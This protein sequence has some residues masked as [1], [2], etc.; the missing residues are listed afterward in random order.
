MSVHMEMERSLTL[1]FVED[2]EVLL[3]EFTMLIF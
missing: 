2:W 1:T 3:E